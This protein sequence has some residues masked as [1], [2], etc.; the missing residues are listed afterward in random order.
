MCEAVVIDLVAGQRYT[1]AR[2][3][4][5]VGG[6]VGGKVRW[7]EEFDNLQRAGEDVCLD[8]LKLDL[9]RD[10]FLA[11]CDALSVNLAQGDCQ[12]SPYAHPF[13][14]LDVV[15]LKDEHKW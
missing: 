7:V 2:W 6:M 3:C 8:H 5:G 14:S 9:V 10:G 1:R 15:V 13:Y 12:L 11:G 4:A